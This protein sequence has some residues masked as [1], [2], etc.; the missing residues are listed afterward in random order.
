MVF[1]RSRSNNSGGCQKAGGFKPITIQVFLTPPDKNDYVYFSP[2]GDA[3]Y[4]RYR[5]QIEQV[6]ETVDPPKESEKQVDEKIALSEHS[7][8]RGT[9]QFC[10]KI[11]E[12]PYIDLIYSRFFEPTTKSR[13]KTTHGNGSISMIYSD[14]EKGVN[15][16]VMTTA[17]NKAQTL[18]VAEEYIRPVI[19][20]L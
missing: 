6:K 16:T 10:R 9:E 14:G 3:F 1:Q 5:F 19:D 20:N 17:D 18:K 15:L 13:L 12:I 8:P 7:Y 11:A 2:A 4:K